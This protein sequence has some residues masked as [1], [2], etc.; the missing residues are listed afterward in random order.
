ME[1]LAH[2]VWGGGTVD[3]EWPVVIL[4]DTGDIREGEVVS[5]ETI[6]MIREGASGQW[7][8]W[9]VMRDIAR[10]YVVY[11]D[12]L[13][14]SS[15]WRVT[16]RDRVDVTGGGKR[17]GL[18]RRGAQ[19]IDDADNNSSHGTKKGIIWRLATRILRLRTCTQAA[20]HS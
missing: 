2:D 4:W 14:E 6:D 7:T 11:G 3:E 17:A 19:S 9:R 1:Q 16:W 13:G 8:L 10:G 12:E 15:A 18:T 5:S 20:T